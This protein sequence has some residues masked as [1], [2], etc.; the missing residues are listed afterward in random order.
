ML[1]YHVHCISFPISTNFVQIVGKI[2]NKRSIFLFK[3]ASLLLRLGLK[4]TRDPQEC[5]LNHCWVKWVCAIYGV[6]VENGE[7]VCVVR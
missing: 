7:N 1:L 5:V 6:I 2:A 4:S 3:S